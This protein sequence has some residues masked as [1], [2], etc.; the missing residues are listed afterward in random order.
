MTQTGFPDIQT[1]RSAGSVGGVALSRP[2]RTLLG[3]DA[4]TDGA[5]TY[6]PLAAW[7]IV[8][9]LA[10]TAGAGLGQAAAAIVV[11]FGMLVALTLVPFERVSR[12]LTVTALVP[13]AFA[14]AAPAWAWLAAGMLIALAVGRSRAPVVVS[15]NDLERHLTWCRRRDEQAD[16]LTAR[17]AG[18][19]LPEPAELVRAFRITDSVELR[20]CAD[21]YDLRAVLDHRELDRVG[22]ERRIGALCS[23]PVAWGWALF[24]H[25]GF[26]L[27]VLV[28]SA[29]RSSS[30]SVPAAH[31]PPATDE[32]RRKVA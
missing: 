15:M 28:E 9:A 32:S 1:R 30:V 5:G 12:V 2:A 11:V 14:G 16:V 7:A 23:E 20:R 24:P 27:D 22:I 25:D 10:L 3:H 8:A 17:I 26:T 29:R 21:G 13:A 31:E 4:E 19:T 18:R 6:A